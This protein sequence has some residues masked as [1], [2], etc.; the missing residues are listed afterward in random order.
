[1]SYSSTVVNTEN[2]KVEKSLL[3]LKREVAV[4]KADQNGAHQKWKADVK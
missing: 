4:E 2:E 1:M 3:V